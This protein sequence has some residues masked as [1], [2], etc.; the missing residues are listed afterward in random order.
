MSNGDRDPSRG[1]S[2]AIMGTV[3]YRCNHPEP[4][5]VHWYQD[6]ARKYYVIYIICTCLVIAGRYFYFHFKNKENNIGRGEAT[7]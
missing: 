3:H 7:C 2:H 5:S 4:V 1:T 6:L